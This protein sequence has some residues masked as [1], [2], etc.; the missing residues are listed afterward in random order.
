[1]PHPWGILFQVD[2][3]GRFVEGPVGVDYDPI[4][5]TRLL[6]D[7]VLESGRMKNLSWVANRVRQCVID[8]VL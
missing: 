7:D 1:V 8:E 6:A 5:T 4:T 3:D 2:D